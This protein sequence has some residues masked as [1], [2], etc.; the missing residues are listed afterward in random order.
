MINRFVAM[1]STAVSLQRPAVVDISTTT[2]DTA[3]LLSDLQALPAYPPALF[4][5]LN[6][7]TL[8]LFFTTSKTIYRLDLTVL[9]AVLPATNPEN[10]SLKSVLHSE[11]VYKATFDIR[12]LSSVLYH[13][14][15]VSLA[16]FE[17]IQLMEL[18][19]CHSH[20]D[21]KPRGST[22]YVLGYM[23]CV[24]NNLP[25][26]AVPSCQRIEVFP[27]LFDVYYKYFLSQNRYGMTNVFWLVMAR[28]PANERI[29][30]SKK[31]CHV[32]DDMRGPGAFYGETLDEERWNW[33]EN[34]LE[35]VYHG[36]L[37]LIRMAFG[38]DADPL[39][40]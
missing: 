13:N 23:A 20:Q 29:D 11:K 24:R 2:S 5:D 4:L 36:E 27:A 25:P 31:G 1:A 8:L 28:G 26:A 18:A 35:E 22:G 3:A 38:F 21:R 39:L 37:K 10:T 7:E 33:N 16:K 30:E 9:N 12:R 15:K 14:Y 19:H 17:D 32:F 40:W 34:L 6:H